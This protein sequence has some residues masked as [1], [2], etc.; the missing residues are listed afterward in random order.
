MAVYIA[1]HTLRQLVDLL[2]GHAAAEER[3]EGEVAPPASES[4]WKQL[5][6]KAR[7]LTL[8]EPERLLVLV[9]IAALALLVPF[10]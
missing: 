5:N 4:P 1:L 9:L 2:G 3:G 8:H 7:L 6:L 10:A